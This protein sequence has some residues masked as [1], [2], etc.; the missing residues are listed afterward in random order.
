MLAHDQVFALNVLVAL[1][2]FD[3][4]VAEAERDRLV[5]VVD[6][7]PASAVPRSRRRSSWYAVWTALALR[8]RRVDFL[9]IFLPRRLAG[10]VQKCVRRL[11]WYDGE[12]GGPSV[13]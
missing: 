5:R 12:R 4:H 7:I 6:T 8:Q 1:Y 13:N 9:Y 3:P 10:A 11:R 2:Q